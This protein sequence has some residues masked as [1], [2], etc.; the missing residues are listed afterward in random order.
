MKV[1][2]HFIYV[3]YGCV[4]QSGVVYSLNNDTTMSFWLHLTPILQILPPSPLHHLLC[5][6]APKC[7]STAYEGAQTL[8]MHVLWMRDAERGGLQPQQ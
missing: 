8:Y 6:G 3:Y 1:V 5:K 2:K 7:H 4:I